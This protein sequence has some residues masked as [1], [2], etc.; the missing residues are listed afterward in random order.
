MV[1]IPLALDQ[2]AIAARVARA[3]A[4]QVLPVMR[5][6]APRIRAAILT[7]LHDPAF[8]DAA[9]AIQKKLRLIRGAEKAAEVIE[10]A[11]YKHAEAQQTQALDGPKVRRSAS[12]VRRRLSQFS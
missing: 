12:K 7:V 8:R 3:G 6:S 9:T 5:L 4:A 10:N 11:L 2:P 1:A